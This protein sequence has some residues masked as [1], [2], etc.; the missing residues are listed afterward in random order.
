MD[1]PDPRVQLRIEGQPL[2]Q[3]RHADQDQVDAAAVM[4]VAENLQPERLEPIRFTDDENLCV[5]WLGHSVDLCVRIKDRLDETMIAAAQPAQL[6][7][8][9][10]RVRQG[11]IPCGAWSLPSHCRS[12]GS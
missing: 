4:H 1:E 8:E 2:L 11:L 3:A 7:I 9:A 10:M 12:A 5:G 6:L